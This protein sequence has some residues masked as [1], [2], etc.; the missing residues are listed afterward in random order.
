MNFP[1]PPRPVLQRRSRARCEYDP[2]A[3]RRATSPPL[4]PPCSQIVDVGN[5]SSSED[6]GSQ[7]SSDENLPAKSHSRQN[8]GQEDWDTSD[9]I[10][11]KHPRRLKKHR[12]RA[13]KLKEILKPILGSGNGESCV[14]LLCCG[15]P[16]ACRVLPV[17]IPTSTVA[18]DYVGQ[19]SLIKDSWNTFH[20]SWR[21]RLP[22]YD[23]KQVSL[24]SVGIAMVPSE[25]LPLTSK[26]GITTSTGRVE[27]F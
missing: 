4:S 5:N 19:W 21:H 11:L 10:T 16:S 3:A 20:K 24:A 14:L 18:T 12:D 8:E 7:L 13:E 2:E 25:I 27:Q 1:K 26:T 22:F 15:S 6:R 23:V 17:L 9:E